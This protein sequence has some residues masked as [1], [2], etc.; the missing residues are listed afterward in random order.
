MWENGRQLLETPE[1]TFSLAPVP[2]GWERGP[3]GT[4]GRVSTFRRCGQGRVRYPGRTWVTVRKVQDEWS[5][6]V[7]AVLPNSDSSF[8]KRVGGPGRTEVVP[9]SLLG[10][11]TPCTGSRGRSRGRDSTP[12]PGD[13][14]WDRGRMR[15]VL[16]RER[17]GYVGI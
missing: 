4:R 7:R 8:F 12:H 11:D 13:D 15:E 16:P 5:A 6:P 3:R 2:R 17:F 1:E 10:R 14:G 9:V